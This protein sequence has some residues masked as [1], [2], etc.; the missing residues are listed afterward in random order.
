MFLEHALLYDSYA[1]YLI[2]H[3]NVVEADKVYEI[4]ISRLV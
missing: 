2:A 3:G 1:Q 4:G